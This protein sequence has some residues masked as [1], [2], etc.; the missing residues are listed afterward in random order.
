[1]KELMDKSFPEDGDENDPKYSR[2]TILFSIS[3][4]MDVVIV[5]FIVHFNKYDCK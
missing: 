1:M 4:I 5:H 2:K 3:M